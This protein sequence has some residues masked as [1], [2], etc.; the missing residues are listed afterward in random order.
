MCDGDTSPDNLTHDGSGE[1][2]IILITYNVKTVEVLSDLTRY[3]TQAPRMFDYKNV[4][5]HES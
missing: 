2:T 3:A 5:Q 4:Y 1:Q